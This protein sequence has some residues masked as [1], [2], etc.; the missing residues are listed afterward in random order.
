[1]EGF[2]YGAKVAL[3]VVMIF[4]GVG[5]LALLASVLTTYHREETE[6]E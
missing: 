1:M 6:E 5:C 2:W 4:A 3:M